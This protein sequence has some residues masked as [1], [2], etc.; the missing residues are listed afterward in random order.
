MKNFLLA[1]CVVFLGTTNSA[2]S[3]ESYA[4]E[5]TLPIPSDTE[6]VWNMVG[7]F[8]DVDD[9]HPAVA[10]CVLKVIDGSLHR[11]LTLNDG[12]EFIEKRIA[13]E[14]GLSYTYT[15]VSSPLAVERYT[16]TFSIS[17]G[18]ASAITW[19]G[20]FKSDDPEM[21]AIFAGIYEAGLEAIEA[22][23]SE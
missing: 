18:H 7:D 1:S 8:C 3:A 21:E 5:R 17:H 9:W 4:V 10:T 6:E 22:R 12:A 16:A 13:V 23:L 20:R 14:P 19:S 15:I 11:V 2:V